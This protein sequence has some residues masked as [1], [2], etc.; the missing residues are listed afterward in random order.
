MDTPGAPGG[1][2]YAHLEELLKRS[3][4]VAEENQKILKRME[5]N[6]L[7]GFIA[8]VVVW[9]VLLGVPLFFLSSYLGPLVNLLTGGAG[10]PS[11]GSLIPSPEQLN[12]LKDLYTGK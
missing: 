9:L 3:L 8:K 11:G 7:I 5:R 6:A 10:S 2:P 12:E 1:M 4:E